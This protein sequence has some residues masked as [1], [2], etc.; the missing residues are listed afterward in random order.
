VVAAAVLISRPA[1]PHPVPTVAA[2]A[3]VAVPASAG[4]ARPVAG[5][6]SGGVVYLTFDD[7]PL[8]RTPALLDRLAQLNLKAT[9]FVVGER[10]AGREGVVR[11]EVAEGHS[12]QNHSFHH[13][14]LVTGVDLDG[15]ARSPWGAS[16][17][18]SELRRTS[19]AL[20]AAGAPR[21]TE[22]RP[23]YG[24]VDR[25]VDDA[26]RRT[27]LRLV[28]PWSDDRSGNIVDSHDTEA[29]VTADDVAA[30]VTSGLR[31]GAIVSMHDGEAGPTLNSIAALQAIVDA[32]N[33]KHL[34]SSAGIRPD[35]T[36][37]VFTTAPAKGG[38]H[39]SS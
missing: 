28:M 35:A 11:R 34:C 20:V 12:V 38:A 24:A 33:R 18:E 39:G 22:Y 32:M 37:G 26:A 15:M 27:G 23:P 17:I 29:G 21:P 2:A 31:A 4:P 25:R 14:N 5:D 16:Q 36:G 9:F 13:F 6:C 8:D 1:D 30:N 7:G 10:I 19:E 3:D